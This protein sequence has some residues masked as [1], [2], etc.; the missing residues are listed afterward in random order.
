MITATTTAM[1]VFVQGKR[2]NDIYGCFYSP[3]VQNPILFSSFS[4]LLIQADALFDSIQFPQSFLEHRRFVN[5]PGRPRKYAPGD[6]APLRPEDIPV[7][8]HAED[9]MGIAC[10]C[11]F[12]LHVLYR[13]HGSWQGWIRWCETGKEVHFRSAFELLYLFI[14]AVTSKESDQSNAV[15]DS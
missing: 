14:E 10:L 2:E 9:S 13:Q 5:L 8:F 12:Q 4:D 11:H 7:Y 3:L 1:Q 15:S 6:N